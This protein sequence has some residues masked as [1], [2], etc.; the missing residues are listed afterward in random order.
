MFIIVSLQ[1]KYDMFMYFIG[2]GSFSIPFVSHSLQVRYPFC[3]RY[4]FCEVLSGPAAVPFGRG[5]VAGLQLRFRQ[6]LLRGWGRV[7]RRHGCANVGKE[8]VYQ[9]NYDN[10]Y[11]I[12]SYTHTII[13]RYTHIRSHIYIYLSILILMANNPIIIRHYRFDNFIDHPKL[14]H[15]RLVVMALG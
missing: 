7:E 12:H 2:F 11:N 4:P 13:N 6:L 3:A 5:A 8:L 15:G 14:I 9:G 1:N 10:I